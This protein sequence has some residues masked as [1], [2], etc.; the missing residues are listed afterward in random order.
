ML[1]AIMQATESDDVYC[2]HILTFQFDLTV[3]E[4]NYPVDKR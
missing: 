1:I 4:S 3:K 2:R